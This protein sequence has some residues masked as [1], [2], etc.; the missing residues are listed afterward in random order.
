MGARENGMSEG[1]VLIVDDVPKNLQ[2][3]GSM[4]R[5]FGFDV[6]FASGG[7]QALTLARARQPDLVLLDVMMPE[8]DGYATCRA[9]K[10]DPNLQKI[11]ILF[12]TAKTE[13]DDIVEGFEAGGVDYVTKP[14]RSVELL[15]RV[16][17]QIQLGRTRRE[18]ALANEELK[19]SN[20]SK[21]RFL[22]IL[23]HDLRGPFT[24]FLSMADLLLLHVRNGRQ[25]RLEES[26]EGLRGMV[27][28]LH[29]LLENLLEWGRMQKEGIVL[30]PADFRASF[31]LG[32]VLGHLKD[33]AKS[34]DIEL[35][36]QLDDSLEVFGDAHMFQAVARNLIANAIK[37]SGRGSEVM[38]R[39]S[40][41]GDMALIE[42]EDRGIG[43][44]EE[45]LKQ[46]FRVDQV[47]T[48]SG[49]EEERGTGLG[50]VL[51]HDYVKKNNGEL[52]AQS[53]PREGSVFRFTIP[54]KK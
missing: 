24:V 4:L 15:A 42:V 46:L 7:P 32:K 3:L 51:C 11:P 50:L 1:L 12:L 10:E 13:T 14:F 28:R 20:H 30:N 41:K 22:S 8:M 21:E 5:T 39:L 38:I 23:A 19:V 44:D 36:S 6:A 40:R 48:R 45:I 31:E 29:S 18:L 54:L 17:T 9:F 52:W 47:V 33:V 25:D 27:Q 16:R 37:F 2:V 53:R 35:V 34:K 43:M 49:T 26:V